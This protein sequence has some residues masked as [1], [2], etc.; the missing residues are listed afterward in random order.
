MP[1]SSHAG[2]PSSWIAVSVIFT[3]FVVGGVAL[4]LGPNWIVFWAGVA[5][6]IGGGVLAV[7]VDIFS[8]VVVDERKL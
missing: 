3:G 8:D 2:R 7:V 6:V 4:P 1:D 5:I